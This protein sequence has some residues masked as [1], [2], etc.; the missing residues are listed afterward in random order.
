MC[1]HVSLILPSRCKNPVHQR[2]IPLGELSLW[3]GVAECL[4]YPWLNIFLVENS[5]Y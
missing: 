5:P 4:Y 1:E 2:L 3:S